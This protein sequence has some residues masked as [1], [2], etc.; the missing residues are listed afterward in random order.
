MLVIISDQLHAINMK[1]VDIVTIHTLGHNPKTFLDNHEYERITFS[2]SE[3]LS[4]K[5]ARVRG[6]EL[7]AFQLQ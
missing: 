3:V 5:M 2:P 6:F 7:Q 1:W 4:H